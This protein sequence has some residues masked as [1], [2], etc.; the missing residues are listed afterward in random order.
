MTRSNSAKNVALILLLSILVACS[1]N[2]S[3][4]VRSVKGEFCLVDSEFSIAGIKRYDSKS[5]IKYLLKTPL[6]ISKDSLLNIEIWQ[7]NNL[8]LEFYNDKV[9]SITTSSAFIK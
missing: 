8:R 9:W 6:K 7:Y 5:H 4:I 1:S 3:Q 2:K